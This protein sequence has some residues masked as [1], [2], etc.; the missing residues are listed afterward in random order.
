L[1]LS[2]AT[3]KILY[4]NK[5][6]TADISAH[7]LSLSYSDKV[8]GEADEFQLNLEDADGLW[9]N[10]W[11]PEKGA[12]L[13]AEIEQA[14]V[15]LQC[16]T[17]SIDEP[18]FNISRSSGDTI[19][20]KGIS[21]AF[22]KAVRTKK[23][24]A[25]ENKT[26]LEIARSVAE[27]HG[28]TIQGNIPDI[29][30]ARVTQNHKGDMQFLQSLA[31]TYGLIFSVKG[32]VM[33]FTDITTLEKGQ[34]ILTINKEALI[35]GDIK[36]KSSQTYNAANVQFH[37]PDDKQLVQYETTY[38]EVTKVVQ[39]P[40]PPQYLILAG[41]P[42]SPLGDWS[43]PVKT[44]SF[45]TITIRTKAENKQQAQR[46]GQTKLYKANSFQKEGSINVPGNPLLVSGVNFQLVHIGKLSG[47]YHVLKSEHTYSRSDGYITSAEIKQVGTVA[48]S[49]YKP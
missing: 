30:I 22:T 17:F 15:T 9:K 44:P 27:K 8:E 24:T 31:N 37:N 23:F 5:N 3:Y 2:P 45:D 40:Q 41:K 11:Y 35:S 34:S 14:G 32:T 1:N 43:L 13:V 49:L 7:L 19:S 29:P 42:A 25:H 46:I 10:E 18:S 16:G 6:I 20:I 33:V 28:F 48:E 26:L 21:A 38:T 47:V 12:T 36:D 39:K 4:N